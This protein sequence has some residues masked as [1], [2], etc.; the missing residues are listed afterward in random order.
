V[1]EGVN[2]VEFLLTGEG[3]QVLVSASEDV[4]VCVWKITMGQPVGAP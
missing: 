2:T 4:G 3:D 1:V